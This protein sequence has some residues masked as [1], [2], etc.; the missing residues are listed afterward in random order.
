M[1]NY[2]IERCKEAMKFAAE[3][4]Y[5]QF[6]KG[7][8]PYI[9]HPIAV[10]NIV[11]EKGMDTDCIITALF[12]DLLE[13][14]D[15]TEEEI[16]Y[17]GGE[18][19]LYSVKLLTKTKEYNMKDYIGEIKSDPRAYAVKGADRLHNLRCAVYTDDEFRKKYIKETLEWYMDFDKEI[20][21]AVRDLAE[22]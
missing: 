10:A 15:A 17:I 11:K 5:G 1:D 7:G 2:D 13:D 6:R 8:L 3:K 14:T 20:A 18:N 12:H 19:V 9:T 16:K 21:E 22:A 4:H